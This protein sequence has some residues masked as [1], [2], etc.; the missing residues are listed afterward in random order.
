MERSPGTTAFHTAPDAYGTRR[1]ATVA[2]VTTT[3]E[4][5]T[6]R[7]ADLDGELHYTD[8]GGPAGAPLLVC[9]HGLGGSSV[10]WIAV[11]P[12]LTGSFRVL[13]PDLAGH[14]RTLAG[15]R[16]TD[17]NAN[18]RLLDRFLREVSGTPAILVGNSMGGLIALL[19][20][21]RNPETVVG[22]VLVDPALPREQR[23]LP[24]REVAARF[25]LAALP[26]VGERYMAKQRRQR[27]PERLVAETLALC[28]V[29]PSRVPEPVVAAL[30]DLARERTSQHGT[31]AAYLG[32]AR[33]IV[34]IMARPKALLA[35]IDRVNQPTLLISGDQ[36]RLVPVAAARAMAARRPEWRYEERAGIGHVPQLEDPEWTAA[37]IHDWLAKEGAGAARAA[38][39]ADTPEPLR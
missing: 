3:Y 27:T 32:A 5:G 36:D 2:E 11:A 21:G 35:R 30:V 13:A 14:G 7:Y 38:A 16:T 25:A 37:T 28:C 17:V 15:T 10:N 12:L 33:S 8:H 19:Q 6:S 1:V 9:V 18:Q 26:M 22:L 4:P 31:I 39:G 24:D 23:G 20:A 29:D 34:K